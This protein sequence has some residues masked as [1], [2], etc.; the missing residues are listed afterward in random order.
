VPNDNVNE[1][2]AN[3]PNSIPASDTSPPPS[4]SNPPPKGGGLFFGHPPGLSTLFF[5]EM[6]ERFS[7]YGMRAILVLYMV[8]EP[9][10]GGMGYS[11]EHATQIYGTYTMLVYMSSIPGGFLA[12]K[13]FG[14]RLAVFIGGAIIALGHFTMAI[15]SIQAFY[16]GLGLIIFGTGLLKPNISSIVGSLYP[17]EDKRRDSGFSIFYMG[18]NVGG[19]ISPLVCGYLAQSKEF[20]SLL[21]SWH[22][23]PL[24]SWHYGFAAAGFGML[25]GLTQYVLGRKR[26]GGAGEKPDRKKVKTTQATNAGSAET[27]NAGSAEATNAAGAGPLTGD[28]LKR[29]GAIFILFFFA[30][31]FWS[32]YEQ[33]GSSLNVFADQL[34]DCSIFGWQYPSS[35]LQS[36]QAVFVIILAPLFSVLWLK[37]GRREPSSPAKFAY[38]LLFLGLGIALMVPA[39]FLAHHGKV[40]ALWLVAV[41]FLEVVGEMCLS[42]VGLSTVTK[43]APL[44]FLGLSM[45]VWYLSSAFGN[46]IAGL[47]AGTFNA[48]DTMSMV[49]LFG[50]MAGAAMAAALIL[51]FLTPTVRKLMTG[52]H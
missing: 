44:R 31:L 29:I 8:A 25:L 19:A 11:M 45:G 17:V 50:S 28:E 1:S 35:W 52:I 2:E 43:L 10:Q 49:T 33:G 18:V 37:L 36:Y 51:L 48:A 6:W 20:R 9:S 4:D 7:Y 47:F 41:Y 14:F 40:N 22:L 27:T 32:V 38:G 26:L 15:P 46:K 24:S 3:P 12:D 39:A 42:P 5:T 30:L 23:D 16:T 21:S 34:V 13:V